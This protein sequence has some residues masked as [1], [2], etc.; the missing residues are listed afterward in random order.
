MK[1]NVKVMLLAGGAW[2]L[3]GLGLMMLHFGYVPPFNEFLAIAVGLLLAGMLTTALLLGLLSVQRT[4]LGRWAVQLSYL[5]FAPIG[6]LT[7]LLAPAPPEG[8]E[9]ALLLLAPFL[10]ALLAS[11]SVAIGMGL[12][13]LVAVGAN[14]LSERLSERPVPIIHS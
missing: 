9:L 7:A 11:L 12:V 14:Q 13:G 10:I 4:P 3:I 6:L 2:A 1:P 8:A 5:L